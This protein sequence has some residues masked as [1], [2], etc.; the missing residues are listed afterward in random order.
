M[1][2]LSYECGYGPGQGAGSAAVASATFYCHFIWGFS[3]GVT[4]FTY[5]LTVVTR[6]LPW[7]LEASEV[8]Q[9][10]KQ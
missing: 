9:M 5:L 6:C 1:A 8:F 7:T 2:F 10:L 4:P 3:A